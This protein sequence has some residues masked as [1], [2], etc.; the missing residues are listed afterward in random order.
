VLESGEAT[1]ASGRQSDQR[2]LSSSQPS[3]A[4]I[5]DDSSPKLPS[6][7]PGRLF[8]TNVMI[9]CQIPVTVIVTVIKIT[10]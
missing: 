1:A 10:C 7:A 5:S 2:F 6:I 4:N 9:F 3:A 8:V